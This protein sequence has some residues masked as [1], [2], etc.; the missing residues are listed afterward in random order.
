MLIDKILFPFLPTIAAAIL[1]VRP[2]PTTPMPTMTIE[3]MQNNEKAIVIKTTEREV[4]NNGLYCIV[5]TSFVFSNPNSRQLAAEFSFPI[6]EGATVCGY[7]LEINGE[8]V[9]GV[10]CEKEKARIAFENEQRRRVDPGLVEHVKG[11]VWKTRIF[12]LPPNGRR[13]AEV[14]YV[15]PVSNAKEGLSVSDCFNGYLYTAT[16][17]GI[18][19][20]TKD[21]KTIC[22]EFSDGWILWDASRSCKD[23]LAQSIELLKALPE[24]GN[25]QVVVF[26]DVPETPVNFTSREQ[27][28]TALKA[29]PFD[30]GTDLAALM[31]AVPDDGKTKLV[32]TDEMDTLNEKIADIDERKDLKLVL[33]PQPSPRRISVERRKLRD[34]ESPAIGKFGR[35]LAIAWAANRISDLSYQA[36]ARKD[37]FL[38][39][40]REFGVASP[41]TSLIVLERLEQWLEHKIEPPKELA[42]HA[43]WVKRRAEADDAIAKKMGN[44]DFER[45]LLELWQERVLWWNNPKPKLKTPKSGLFDNVT[46]RVERLARPQPAAIGQYSARRRS[47]SVEAKSVEVMAAWSDEAMVVRSAVRMASAAGSRSSAKSKSS[48]GSGAVP[49]VAATVTLKAWDPKTSY[50]DA[51]KAAAKEEAYKVYLTESEQFGN[52]PA[53][54]LDCAGWFFSVG[55]AKLAKRI[56][57]NLAEFKLEDSA[58]WR[59]MGWRLREAKA[60]DESVRA[61][62]HLLALRGEE[63]QSY[64]DLALVLVERGKWRFA[65]GKLNDAAADIAEAMKM[66]HKCIFENHARRSARRSNDIQ[67]AIIALEE[68][69][70]LIWW[71]AEQDWQSVKPPEPPEMDASYRRDLPMDLRIVLSWDADETDI[72]IHVLEPNC[73]E[74]YYGHRRT[75]EGGFVGE[76][77]T[78]GYGP[79]EYLAKTAQKGIFKVLCNYFASHQQSLTGPVS[80]TATVYTNWS[81]KDEKS[82]VL[83]LRL[84]KPKSKNIIGE[85]IID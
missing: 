34:G 50:I 62:R 38:Q 57:S 72:D 32:F 52:S 58:L 64:R 28:I 61:L 25:W 53:F 46:T 30:G 9:P 55:E 69:N 82:Q 13:R 26:R 8:M 84:D 11:N 79:E 59:V 43:E 73:E 63:G 17:A 68:L 75:R 12:P 27:L 24:K 67:A 39:L 21:V 23:K 1:P 54:Y 85:I 15:V 44:A 41:V 49:S 60:Y 56:I 65:N 71:S 76:D 45:R 83:T 2:H 29:E 10:V 6:P 37:E 19:E 74:A 16:C 77:V 80:V 22:A 81:R 40:G 20:T 42:I 33:R 35:L 14:S 31:S 36:D 5:E 47:T 78:T 48:L 66:F 18:A 4:V 51:I 3:N 70:A 7:K